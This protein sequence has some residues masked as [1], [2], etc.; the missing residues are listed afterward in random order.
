MATI[1][2]AW[3]LG[4]KFAVGQDLGVECRAPREGR[5][6]LGWQGV[7]SKGVEQAVRYGI[8]DAS[9]DSHHA[10]MEVLKVVCAN[11]AQFAEPYYDQERVLASPPDGIEWALSVL[12]ACVAFKG[13]EVEQVLRH[14]S[15]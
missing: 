13:G 10:I 11:T 14:S 2:G 15:A 4:E 3:D 5:R 8:D 7:R 12:A 1:V 9:D 6:C